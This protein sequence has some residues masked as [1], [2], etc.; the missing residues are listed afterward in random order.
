MAPKQHRGLTESTRNRLIFD[1]DI[2]IGYNSPNSGPQYYHGN[3][4]SENFTMKLEGGFPP[5]SQ[6]STFSIDENYRAFRPG[7]RYNLYEIIPPP[8]ATPSRVRNIVVSGGGPGGLVAALEAIDAGHNVTLLESRTSFTR[9]QVLALD[10]DTIATLTKYIGPANMAKLSAAG[11]K[12]DIG[13]GGMMAIKNVQNSLLLALEARQKANPDKVKI[14]FGTQLDFARS[15]PKGSELIP[16]LVSD[17]GKAVRQLS[18]KPDLIIGA[19][20]NQSRV[21]EASNIRQANVGNRT[22]A[23]TAVFDIKKPL[24]GG[25]DA[26]FKTFRFDTGAKYGSHLGTQNKVGG[27]VY[28]YGE[29]SREDWLLYDRIK[30][31][32]AKRK[33]II[34]Y[35]VRQRIV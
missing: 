5:V 24:P 2:I 7:G 4:D 11:I 35:H 3:F 22:H 15:G 30:D 31:P 32:E 6:G 1:G 8:P 17:S 18:S 23:F 33:W 9:G 25:T 28:F 12:G 19:D 26:I 29:L 21:G 20:S 16:V 27:Q 13:G 34:D 10:P 14:E